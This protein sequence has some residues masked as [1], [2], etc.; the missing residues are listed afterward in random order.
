MERKTIEVEGHSHHITLK[1]HAV[2]MTNL[3]YLAEMILVTFLHHIFTLTFQS[4]L[5]GRK[6]LRSV[7]S[8]GVER[9][10]PSP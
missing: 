4:V 3:D 9:F 6:S 7:H 1:A 10:A 5:N 8:C 2:S